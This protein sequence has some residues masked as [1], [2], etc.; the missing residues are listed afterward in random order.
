PPSAH[1]PSFPT[2]R[3]SDLARRAPTVGTVPMGLATI[4]PSP[5]HASAQQPRRSR[6]GS[7]CSSHLQPPGPELLPRGGRVLPLELLVALVV[8]RKSTRLNSSH[9]SISY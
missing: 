2:R 5:R 8:D 4:S 9:V 6:P 1:L 7:A 3:S